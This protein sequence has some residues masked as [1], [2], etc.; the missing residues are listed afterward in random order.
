MHRRNVQDVT[1]SKAERAFARATLPFHA[2]E[3]PP[4]CHWDRGERGLSAG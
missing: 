3:K 2:S 1:Q 4:V